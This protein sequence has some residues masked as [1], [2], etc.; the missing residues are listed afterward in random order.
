MTKAR[1]LANFVSTGNPL[2]DGTL[3]VADISDLTASAAEL[4]V[5][6]GVTSSTAELNILDGVTATANELNV[7]DG[8]TSSTAE[9]NVLDG[10]TS[11]T[12]ELNILDGATVTTAELNYVSGVT[13]AV[14]SQ[15]NAKASATD[16]TTAINGLGTAAALDVGT[17]ANQVVQLDGS[18]R[19]PAVDGGQLTN[20]PGLTTANVTSLIQAQSEW[21]LIKEI[22]L[23]GN[24]TSIDFS[25][26]EYNTVTYKGFRAYIPG[27]RLYSSISPYVSWKN[28]PSNSGTFWV[29]APDGYGTYNGQNTNTMYL[30]TQSYQS[31]SYF[32]GDL[33]WFIGNKP[34]GFWNSWGDF[35]GFWG[36]HT[37]TGFSYTGTSGSDITGLVLNG[38]ALSADTS[39]NGVIVYVYGMRKRT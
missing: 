13:S 4:N 26:A 17:G 29:R 20:I 35:Y 36:T 28:S 32:A 24:V 30:S 11:S 21:E 25:G 10:V 18:G 8:V 22:S 9:L 31:N 5:L 3:A 33:T 2:A 19:L 12:A 15:L 34:H 27:F 39:S 14:Q 1:D 23:S 16:L 7:L 6:D 37:E 38:L